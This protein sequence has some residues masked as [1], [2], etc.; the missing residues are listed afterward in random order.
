MPDTIM[1]PNGKPYRPRKLAAH[2]VVDDDE[3]VGVIVFGTH[4]PGE[5]QP[6]ADQYV[7]Y[8]LESGYTA[9]DPL[10]GWWRDGFESGQRRWVTDEI[11]GRAGIWFREIVCA[12]PG[13][14][15]Q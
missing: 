13:L 3:L 15:E 6:L 12:T 2:A 14:G 9:V 1:R 10:T 8:W 4:D 11:S 5:A 7:P